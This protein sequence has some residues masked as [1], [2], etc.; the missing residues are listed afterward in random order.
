MFDETS[1]GRVATEAGEGGF[2]AVMSHSSAERGVDPR[3]V[4]PRGNNS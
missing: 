2:M 1:L 3:S 4:T